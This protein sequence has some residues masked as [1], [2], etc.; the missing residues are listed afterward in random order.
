MMCAYA[1]MRICACRY[2]RGCACAHVRM[3]GGGPEDPAAYS[4][5]RTGKFFQIVLVIYFSKTK[6][7][8]SEERKVIWIL[9]SMKV[10][11]Q[12]MKIHLQVLQNSVDHATTR[13]NRGIPGSGSRPRTNGSPPRTR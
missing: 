7:E 3:W 12:E 1:Y 11:Q 10:L 5:I 6:S 9:A 13:T 8:N 4:Y 2:I